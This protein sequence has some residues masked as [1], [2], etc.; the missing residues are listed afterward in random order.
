MPDIRR[1]RWAILRN[2]AVVAALIG[3]TVAGIFG[4][5]QIVISPGYFNRH[6][7]ART[8]RPIDIDSGSVAT[9]LG[10]IRTA[11]KARKA[12]AADIDVRRNAIIHLV[13]MSTEQPP[14]QYYNTAIGILVEYVK[15]NIDAR[16]GPFD[17]VEVDDREPET[18]R[19]ADIID[20][21]EALRTIRRAGGNR[22]RVELGG[23]DF[24]RIILSKLD[25]ESFYFGHAD[26]TDAS[27]SDCLCRGAE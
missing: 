27:L 7:D 12:E 15:S 24:H 20:A 26:F 1:G 19:P 22:H 4:I 9:R 25:L 14:E 3:A 5:I 23:T 18:Y 10:N 21:L 2:P 13:A 8:E 6:G 17:Q 11:L 16:R